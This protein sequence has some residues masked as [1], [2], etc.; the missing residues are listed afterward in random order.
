MQDGAIV[1]GYPGVGKT[2]VSTDRVEFIDLES[3]CFY[4]NKQRHPYWYIAYCS[5]AVHLASQGYTVFVSSHKPV[6]EYLN[7]ISPSCIQLSCCV[8]S[9]D[10]KE[11]WIEKLRLR[12]E[13]SGLEPDY[14]AYCRA[15]DHYDEDITQLL[16]NFSDVILITNMVYDL[17]ELLGVSK[18]NS[19]ES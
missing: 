11:Q 4:I 6:Q 13:E 3:K 15:K 9:L 16:Q 14:R 18:K 5:A 7:C 19:E 17:E 1:V 8:P 2:T 10:L 12:Y